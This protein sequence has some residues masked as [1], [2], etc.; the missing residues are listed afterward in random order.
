MADQ[1]R[2]RGLGLIF[3]GVTAAVIVT[4]GWVVAAHVTGQLS[5]DSR[6]PVAELS[7]RSARR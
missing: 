5:L 1:R 3:A 2:L 6:Q 7:A 4:A